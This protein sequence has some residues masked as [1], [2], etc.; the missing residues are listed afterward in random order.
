L[1]GIFQT[2]DEKR[3]SLCL[4]CTIFLDFELVAWLTCCEQQQAIRAMIQTSTIKTWNEKFVVTTFDKSNP[5]QKSTELYYDERGLLHREPDEGPA[6]ITWWANGSIYEVVY[7]WH[8]LRHRE[9]GPA[10]ILYAEK[11]NFAFEEHWYRYGRL[12]RDPREGAA[13]TFWDGPDHLQ[14][15]L[16]YIHGYHFRDPR[17][18]PCAVDFRG[19]EDWVTSEHH[20]EQIPPRPRP[21]LKWLRRTFGPYA[22]DL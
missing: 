18:G 22:R 20:S 16:Y 10:R 17:E 19:R 14:T 3:N 7:C 8:G 6:K 12:H 11:R 1:V 5:Q 4:N 9:D 21:P 13:E 15:K 2:I